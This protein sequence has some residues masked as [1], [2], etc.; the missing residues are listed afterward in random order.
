MNAYC[1]RHPPNGGEESDYDCTCDLY[2]GVRTFVPPWKRDGYS[3]LKPDNAVTFSTI[4]NA[5]QG[6]HTLN[7]Y[8]QV[9]HKQAV[10]W[11]AAMEVVAKVCYGL[12][13]DQLTELYMQGLPAHQA[14]FIAEL[15]AE[16]RRAGYI[17]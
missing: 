14:G 4:G 13:L 11:Q 16:E 8:E 3:V 17:E 6:L 9:L 5:V 10:R 12:K 7:A 2:I 15:E 1:L